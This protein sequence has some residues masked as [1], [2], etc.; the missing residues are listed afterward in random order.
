MPNALDARATVPDDLHHRPSGVLHC[1]GGPRSGLWQDSAGNC[2]SGYGISELVA[3]VSSEW[4]Y[5]DTGGTVGRVDSRPGNGD[6]MGVA[7][8][9]DGG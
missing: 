8:D 9:C 1:S 2:D 3:G 7:V 4:G 6:A 5:Y